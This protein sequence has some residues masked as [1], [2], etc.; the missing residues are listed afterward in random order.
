MT[1]GTAHLEEAS[2][3]VI[4]Q[5][6]AV[7][8]SSVGGGAHAST[9]GIHTSI[10]SGQSASVVQGESQLVD[11]VARV[12]PQMEGKGGVGGGSSIHT[13]PLLVILPILLDLDLADL[14]FR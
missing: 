10:I 11:A 6:P 1:H 5:Y 12:V 2:S 14:E 3:S 4:P 9:L 8:V 13:L 7:V